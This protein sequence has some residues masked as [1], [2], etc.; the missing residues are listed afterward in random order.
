MWNEEKDEIG[1]VKRRDREWHCMYEQ[2][3]EFGLLKCYSKKCKFEL[4]Y[5]GGNEDEMSILWE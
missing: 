2:V 5:K 1:G 3:I 4:K